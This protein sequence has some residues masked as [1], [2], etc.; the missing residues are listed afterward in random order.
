MVF[1]RRRAGFNISKQTPKVLRVSK[2]QSGTLKSIF[3][4]KSRKA[5]Q[6]GKRISKNGKI[7]YETRI[8]RSD[9]EFDI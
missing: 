5:L 3:R 4:D 8:N 1:K 2:A 6:P 9:L 7:Y